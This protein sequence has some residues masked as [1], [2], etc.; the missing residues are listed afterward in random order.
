MPELAKRVFVALIIAPIAVGAAWFGD[1]ALATLLSA[2]AGVAAWELCR[3]ARG[4]GVNTLDGVVI[5]V[6]AAIPLLSHAIRLGVLRPA[7]VWFAA[8]L[9]AIMTIT[10]FRRGLDERP[11][12]V[13]AV[14]LFIA[15]YTGGMLSFAYDLRYH[16]YAIGRT[17]QSLVLLFPVLLTWSSDVGA[18]FTGRLV[19]RTKLMPSVSPAKTVE[20][21]LGGV[22][23]S[24][25]IGFAYVR[26]LLVPGG[27]L[28][29]SPLGIVVFTIAIAV[30]AQL[31]DLFESLL[32]REAEVKDSSGLLPG[33][34]GFLD[35]IDSLLFVLPVA[36][37]LLSGLLI[38]A[39]R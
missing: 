19:G 8:L 29:L 22:A 35:R 3:M 13:A 36:A 1:A 31:G 14:S 38:P 25:L 32:K 2:V 30:A 20:G 34:G 28:G 4:K 23:L 33:H 24:V 16:N 6:A 27:Q 12:L 17:G 21:A 37:L 11:L 18:Y 7:P 10:L 15:M 9:L 5:A 39:P 26:Y